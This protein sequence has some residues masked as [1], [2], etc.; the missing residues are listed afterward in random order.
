MSAKKTIIQKIE[1]CM[2]RIRDFGT[3]EGVRNSKTE[4]E[5]KIR[6]HKRGRFLKIITAGIIAILFLA[7]VVFLWSNAVYTSYSEIS[8]FPRVSSSNN[9]S[10]NHNG[11]DRKSVV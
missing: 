6:A 10:L 7:A 8:S 1:D 3:S 2:A 11:R 9:V 4:F 5:N